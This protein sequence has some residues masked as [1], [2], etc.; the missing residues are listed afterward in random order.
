MRARVR[1]LAAH[2]ALVGALGLVSVLPRT[3]ITPTLSREG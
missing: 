3:A 1:D 2:A